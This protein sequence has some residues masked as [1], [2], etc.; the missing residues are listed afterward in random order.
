MHRIFFKSLELALDNIIKG[1]NM[2]ADCDVVVALI[3]EEGGGGGGGRNENK[4]TPA[5]TVITNRL[6]CK[7]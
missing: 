1:L 6:L 5:V 4:Q 2:C 3:K 7:L